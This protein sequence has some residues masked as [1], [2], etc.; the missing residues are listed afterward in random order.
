VSDE[1]A[2]TQADD[3]S[4]LGWRDVEPDEMLRHGDLFFNVDHWQC[5]QHAGQPAVDEKVYRRRIEPQ[6]PT[7]GSLLSAVLWL[8]DA[9]QGVQDWKGTN[10]GE[11]IDAV[12]TQLVHR[13]TEVQQ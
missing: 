8:I 13:K 1:Q 10:V 5:T 4:G 11:A 12:E 6:Q 7:L 3:P 9:I 2:Q